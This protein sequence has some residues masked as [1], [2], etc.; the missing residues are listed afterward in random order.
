MIGGVVSGYGPLDPIH[1]IL[2]G[3]AYTAISGYIMDNIVFGGFNVRAAYVVTT[4]CEEMK[5]E[6]Y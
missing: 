3:I 4:K 1:L 6:I 2:Y 5:Q